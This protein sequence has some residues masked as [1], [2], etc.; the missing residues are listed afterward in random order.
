MKKTSKILAVVLTLI[1]LLSTAPFFA[2]AKET[3][4][5]QEIK[6]NYFFDGDE[7]KI[8][9]TVKANKGETFTISGI[10]GADAYSVEVI[11]NNDDIIEIESDDYG[12][13]SRSIGANDYG[14]VVVDVT[15]WT[16]GEE[17]VDEDGNPYTTY[18]FLDSYILLIAIN[19]PTGMGNLLGIT[20]DDL[21]F[22]YKQTFDRNFG[23]CEYAYPSTESDNSR[24]AYCAVIYV[25]DT[26]FSS[27]VNSDGL[28][29]TESVGSE[30][31][32]VYAIDA[33]GHIFEDTCTITVA[34]TWWQQ[35]IRIFLLG[36]LWY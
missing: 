16:I 24:G 2:S 10:T 19:D 28:V 7:F 5:P 35:L 4:K 8:D 32:T 3:A 33:A 15:G 20:A 31:C 14:V 27:M 11:S 12:M 26:P 23:Y 9:K 22:R 34:Y 25:P 13:A 30:H 21:T 29:Y 18:D 17:G 6:E 36:F 1:M